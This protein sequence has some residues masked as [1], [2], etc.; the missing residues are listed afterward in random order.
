MTKNKEA[1]RYYSANQ[2]T[3]VA[4][5]V[6]GHRTANSGASKFDGGDVVNEDASLLVECKTV[7]TNKESVSIKKSWLEKIKEEAFEKHLYS[8][9]LAFDFG[10]DSKHQYFIIDEKLMA[11]L[12]EKLAEENS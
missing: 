4:K 1:T 10:P 12:V 2:E 8:T 9:A 6:D 11:Y 3:K 5:I 7:T